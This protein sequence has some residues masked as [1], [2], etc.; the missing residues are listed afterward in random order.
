LGVD[1]S[2]QKLGPPVVESASST[3]M[4]T[5][6]WAVELGMRLHQP[7]PRMMES[8]ATIYSSVSKSQMG[9][10]RRV[11]DKIAKQVHKNKELLAKVVAE[12]PVEGVEG[13]SK[14]LLDV[15]K[16]ASIVGLS[17]GSDE[18]SLLEL[19]S[20]VEEEKKPRNVGSASKVV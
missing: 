13:Y 3:V 16:F 19:F 11:K 6:S 15:V 8:G 1:L 14:V 10:K 20:I 7:Y 5:P 4:N 12:T 2:S 18:K 17:C 9:Y